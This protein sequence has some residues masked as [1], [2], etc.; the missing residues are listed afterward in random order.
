MTT[1]RDRKKREEKVVSARKRVEQHDQGS[2]RTYLAIP[3][4]VTQFIIKK[5]G[6][7]RLDFV[8]FTAGMGNP[9]ADEGS[10]TYER[11]YWVHRGIGANNGTYCCL[12][13]TF[14]KPCPV[15]EYRGQLLKDGGE[16]HEKVADSLK[17]KERQ[18]FAVWD[19]AD[20]EKGVQVWDFP[21]WNFGKHLDNK[22]RNSDEEEG[23]EYFASSSIRGKTLKIGATED[24]GGEYK[25]INCADIEF[26]DRR[27]A[28]PDVIVDSCPCLDT[29]PVEMPYADLKKILLQAP[30][31]KDEETSSRNRKAPATKKSSKKPPVDEDEDDEDGDEGQEEEGEDEEEE[32]V[33]AG[34]GKYKVG[35]FVTYKGKECE[36]IKIKDGVYY[37]ED[38]DG[39][40]YKVT[41]LSRLTPVKVKKAKDEEEEE[42]EDVEETEED[43][44]E[45][46][47]DEDTPAPAKK[48]GPKKPGPKKPG[49]K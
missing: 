33:P 25:F 38:Q 14:G 13:R 44:D 46:E 39:D 20:K 10:D 30:E 8:P 15:C 24:S 31:E 9:F 17:P 23:Y 32:L 11:T 1:S 2:T 29:I 7:F 12:A 19:H 42:E 48:P 22:I 5:A 35:D 6:T 28:L 34:K 18:L 40:D 41:D 16:D 47:G 27:E 36:V 45:D 49:K 43:E 21:W 3:E 4:G 26:K 37:V